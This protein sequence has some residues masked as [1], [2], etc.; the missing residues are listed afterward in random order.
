MRTK[1]QLEDKARTQM[2]LEAAYEEAA[3]EDYEEYQ[4][5]LPTLKDGLEE[6]GAATFIW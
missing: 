2:T 6:R 5:W 1:K 4:A 3:T